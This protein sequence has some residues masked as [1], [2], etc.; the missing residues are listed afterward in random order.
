MQS[1]RLI[2]EQKALFQVGETIELDGLESTPTT[3][4]FCHSFGRVASSF[5][6]KVGMRCCPLGFLLCFD[7]HTLFLFELYNF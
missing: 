2:D 3:Y 7:T 5:P 6:E 1:N 4:A